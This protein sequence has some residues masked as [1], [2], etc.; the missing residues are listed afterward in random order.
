MANVKS[1]NFKEL[2]D[3]SI[4]QVPEGLQLE[5]PADYGNPTDWY[6]GE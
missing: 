1:L 3:K 4:T 2:F 5:L 6:D